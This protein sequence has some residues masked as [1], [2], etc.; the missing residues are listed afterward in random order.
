VTTTS[1]SAPAAPWYE[2]MW[3]KVTRVFG[4][5]EAATQSQAKDPTMVGVAPSSTGST[6]VALA[7]PRASA[8]PAGTAGYAQDTPERT[9]RTGMMGESVKTGMW[10][11][12]AV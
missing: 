10:A 3:D 7:A 11:P 9:I 1:Q 2:R 4:G 5:G 12:S 8:S 6:P